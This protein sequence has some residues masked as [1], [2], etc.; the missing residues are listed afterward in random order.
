MIKVYCRPRSLYVL[1]WHSEAW[2]VKID[3]RLHRDKKR[4]A[5][6]KLASLAEDHPLREKYYLWIQELD[7]LIAGSEARFSAGGFSM[8][9]AVV[10]AEPRGVDDGDDVLGEEIDRRVIDFPVGRGV[11][12]NDKRPAHTN[13]VDRSNC[14]VGVDERRNE[15]MAENQWLRDMLARFGQFAQ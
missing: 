12:C 13:Q 8:H 1:L 10:Q 9:N 5:Q 2:A 11:A 7:D 6:T 14:S 4:L 15:L 3:I